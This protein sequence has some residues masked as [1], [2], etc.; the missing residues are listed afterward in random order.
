MDVILKVKSSDEKLN[1]EWW[2]DD[3][4]ID[5]DDDRHYKISDKGVLSI[6]E[7]EKY[8]EGKYKCIVS[9]TS[10]PVMS[11]SVEAEVNLTGKRSRASASDLC[12]YVM[13][14]FTIWL[15]LKFLILR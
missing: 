8:Y 11:V 2:L 5:K 7:F 4:R 6:Q 14:D 10:Q 9:T 15:L 13:N 3:D 1:Y 12:I